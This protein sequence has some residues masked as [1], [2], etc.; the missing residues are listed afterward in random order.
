MWYDWYVSSH[1]A[2][3]EADE[4][5]ILPKFLYNLLL[6]IDSKDLCP[7]QAY[8]S[9]KTSDIAKIQIPLPPLEVQEQIV[10]ELDGYQ[11][12]IDWAKQIVENYKPTIKIDPDWEMVE[13]GEE[14][15][16][17]IIDWDRWANYPKKEEF[18]KE[19]Y[20]LFLNTS[21]VRK[22]FFDFSNCDFITK[23][24]DEK[25][26]KWK[27]SRW[28]SVLTTRGTLWNTAYFDEKIPYD[29]IRINSWMV[30][31]RP[32]QNNVSWDYLLLFINSQNFTTQ[33]ESFVSWSAQPQLPIRS[34]SQFKIPLPPLEV[35]QQIVAEIE[36]EQAMVESA[37]GL[38]DIFEEKVKEKIGEV[39]G[40]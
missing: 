3:I 35:Q 7:D 36:K 4:S 6:K 31:L 27:L 24:R 29:N 26:S 38:I 33:V 16:V 17:K 1:L 22:W 32:N 20:C 39:W 5:K 37:K 2:T 23:E 19:W 12:I 13:L 34:L 40:E 25:L 9:L 11:K 18:T 21:N 14:D 8:P 10:A 15:Y 30:I 28:D